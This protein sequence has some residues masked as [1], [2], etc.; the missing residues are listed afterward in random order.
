M[1][2]WFRS[3][4]VWEEKAPCSPFQFTAR[5]KHF[6]VHPLPCSLSSLSV[7]K[8]ACRDT[9]GRCTNEFLMKLFLLGFVNRFDN[10]FQEVASAVSRPDLVVEHAESYPWTQRVLCCKRIFLRTANFFTLGLGK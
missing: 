4:E 8:E 2:V 10:G 3:G 5:G 7:D 6:T 1:G 9:Q